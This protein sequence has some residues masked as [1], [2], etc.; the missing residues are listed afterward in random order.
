MNLSF[1]EPVQ[2]F[3]SRSGIFPGP[4]L[5]I[6]SGSG[7]WCTKA[8][9]FGPVP[10]IYT[11]EYHSE[12]ASVNDSRIHLRNGSCELRVFLISILYRLI[13]LTDVEGSCIIRG[14]LSETPGIIHQKLLDCSSRSSGEPVRLKILCKLSIRAKKDTQNHMPSPKN[15]HYMNGWAEVARTGA[16]LSARMVSSL[17]TSHTIAA[18][19]G[20]T[21]HSPTVSIP[22]Y[23]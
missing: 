3:G 16:C 5:S 9:G 6:R 18:I 19:I 23:R 2:K 21:H 1:P 11:S 4:N 17:S 20:S 10:T 15:S 22:A 14:A 8:N 7:T 13:N 12:A